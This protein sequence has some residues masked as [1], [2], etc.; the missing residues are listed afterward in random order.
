MSIEENIKSIG[1]TVP[2]VPRPAA[3][4]IPALQ[5]GD[6]VFTAG[7]VPLVNGELKY[8]GKLGADLTVDEGYAAAK[9]CALNCLA[10]IKGLIGDLDRVEQVVKVVGYVASAA[11]FTDQPK[12]I[13]GA[14]EFLVQVFGETGRHA[15]VAVG[16]AE[17]PLG[18]AVE[19]E[20][21]VRLK[22]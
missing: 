15:R 3:A 17:L 8:K 22:A 11:G 13:N 2:D 1:L 19:V 7:Q 16:V 9:Y 4:Y 20:M 6:M 18:A 12:V 21:T 5:S 10:A 14:S